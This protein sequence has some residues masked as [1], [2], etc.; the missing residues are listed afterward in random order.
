[1]PRLL[2]LLAVLLPAAFAPAAAQGPLETRDSPF[3]T[4]PLNQALPADQAFAL[5]ALVELPDSLV[6]M[7]EIR[8]GYYLYRKSLSFEESGTQDR[9]GEPV[10]P[11]GIDI[12][13]EFFGD[14]EVFYDRLLVR[15]PLGDAAGEV[16]LSVSYQGCAEIGY[17][18][19]MQYKQISVEIPR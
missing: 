4:S 19:P 8:D 10:I 14:V 11:P 2:V 17:C 13:D 1:M 3:Q 15:L 7:W 12:S 16:D 18:Y 9:L 6:L 5:S